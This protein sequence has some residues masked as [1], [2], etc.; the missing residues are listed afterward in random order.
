MDGL[1]QMDLVHGDDHILRRRDCHRE[2]ARSLRSSTR[3]RL[4]TVTKITPGTPYLPRTCLN[5]AL[6]RSAI[7]GSVAA[8]RNILPG[9]SRTRVRA[10]STPSGVDL[11]QQS[12]ETEELESVRQR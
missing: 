8:V 3:K 11:C 9:S 10:E 5:A 7:W 12:V 4:S 1:H 6:A 2:R